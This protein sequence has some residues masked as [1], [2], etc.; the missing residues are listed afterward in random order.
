M[1][2]PKLTRELIAATAAAFCERNGWDA[3]QAADAFG[4]PQI[5][6]WEGDCPPWADEYDEQWNRKE[7]YRE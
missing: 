5:K 4:V 3:D 7:G 6:L 2:R 1:D